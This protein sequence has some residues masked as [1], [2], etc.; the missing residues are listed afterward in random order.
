M[1]VCELVMPVPTEPKAR[2]VAESVMACPATPVPLSGIVSG[3]PMVLLKMDKVAVR[4]PS[5]PGV[6]T[7]EM[8]HALETASEPWQVELGLKSVGLVPVRVMA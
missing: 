1:I 4:A 6:K 2:E 5:A 3:E 8:L 7:S